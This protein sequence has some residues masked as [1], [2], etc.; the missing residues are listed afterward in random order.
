MTDELLRLA[1]E[2]IRQLQSQL[3]EVR[4]ALESAGRANESLSAENAMLYRQLRDLVPAPIRPLEGMRIGIV[5]HPSRE[6]DYREVVERLGGQLL[7]AGAGDKLGLIDR[8]VQK[9]NGTIFLTAW[10]SHKASQ[11]AA[12]AAER[13]GRPLVLFDQP[14]LF[15]VER[16]ILEQLLPEIRATG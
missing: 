14:G 4:A 9:T 10:G 13:Y 2:E 3:A 7:F 12:H 6:A 16:A 1:D 5:G 11:R 8:V 15:S